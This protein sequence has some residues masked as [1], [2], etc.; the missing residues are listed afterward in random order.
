VPLTTRL[1]QK[2]RDVAAIDEVNW[3]FFRLW[4]K[5]PLSIAALSPSGHQLASMMC[6]GIGPD[7]GPVI[8]L[9]GGTG[10]FTRAILDT[11]LP[12][13]KL[14]VVELNLTLFE[15]LKQKFPELR[16]VLGDA[17][18]LAAICRRESFAAPGEIDTVVSGLGLLS[19]P[20]KLQEAILRSAFTM[21]RPGGRLIQFTY[22]PA[23]PVPRSLLKRLKLDADR[24]GFALWNVP[25]ASV[26]EF[27]RATSAETTSAG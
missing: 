23:A 11:G 25:P 26:Y 8:E 4:L 2:L 24:S 16:I 27:A 21:L 10:V 6:R 15:H 17:S 9:G 5:H 3:T 22:G 13:A 7:S 1:Q 19:M 14:M 20:K 12:P 18:D